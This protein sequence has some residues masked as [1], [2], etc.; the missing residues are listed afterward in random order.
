MVVPNIV[1]MG[2]YFDS[3]KAALDEKKFSHRI[4]TEYEELCLGSPV[5]EHQKDY[6]RFFIIKE[7]PKRGR[8][9]EYNQKAIDTHRKNSVG[10]FVLATN[11]IKDPVEALEVYRMKDT[12]EK[13]FDK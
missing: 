2:V 6:E 5:K 7:T 1:G 13:R 4:L 12:I 3:I 9:V 11:D 8:K 10:W